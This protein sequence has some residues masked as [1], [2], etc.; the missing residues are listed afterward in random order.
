MGLVSLVRLASKRTSQSTLK[1]YISIKNMWQRWREHLESKIIDFH[2][3]EP[4]MRNQFLAITW[5]ST[6]RFGNREFKRVYSWFEGTVGPLNALLNYAG[7]R[8]RDL[9]MT[10]YP[11][12]EPESFHIRKYSDG[13]KKIFSKEE[14]DRLEPDHAVKTYWRG[15]YRR[16]GKKPLLLLTHPTLPELDFVDMI[17]AHM[18]ELC[19]QCF[20]HNVP[21][22]DAH[23]YIN[24]LIHRLRP[25]LDWVY[26]DGEQ[27]RPYFNRY[28]D[29]ELREIVQEIR[30]LYGKRTGREK[31]VTKGLDAP[32]TSVLS[33]EEFRD[34]V[35]RLRDSTD[36]KKERAVFSEILNHIDE[37]NIEH[38]DIEKVI[39]Q[40]L[41]LSSREGNEW[42]RILLSDLHHPRSL[43][44]VVFAGDT[45]LDEPSSIL[46]VGEL[47][48]SRGKGQVDLVIFLRRVVYDRAIWTPVMILEIKT[49]T[50][51][52]Y[53][54]YG[55][56]TKNKNVKE[57]APSLYAWKRTKTEDEWKEIFTSDPHPRTLDQ[58][59]AYEVEVLS[60]YKQVAPLDTTPPESLWKGVVVLDT[61]QSP[62]EV[63][64]GFQDLLDDLVT[65]I[66]SDLLEISQT[67]AYSLDPSSIVK[68]PRVAA[69]L[70]PGDGPAELIPEACV[71]DSLPVDNP[72]SERVSDD[73]LL[74]LYVPVSSPTSSGNAAAWISRN[75][76]LL[77]HIQECTTTSPD[78][79]THWVDL[80]GDYPNELLTKKRIGLDALLREGGITTKRYTS[81]DRLIDKIRFI[82]L[83]PTIDQILSGKDLELDSLIDNLSLSNHER[84][85][86]ER[87]VI[88]DG[89]SEFKDTVP[90]SRQH[91]I[92]SLEKRLLN[93]LPTS[94]TNIIWIDSGV[95][96]TRMNKHYQ[97]KC[98]SP[99]PYDSPRKMHVDEIIYNLPTSS[100]GFGRFLPKRDDERFIVQDVPA[101]APPWRTK[102]HVPHL[103][104]YSKK[105]RGGQRRKPMLNE[106]EV[107]G[108]NLRSM[109]RRGVTLSSIYS[110]TSRY[111][112][113]QVSELEEYA[114]TLVPST[115]RIREEVIEDQE[116]E[117]DSDIPPK[118][119]LT[120][121]ITTGK[122]STLASRLEYSPAALPPRPNK[123]EREYVSSMG[124]TRRWFYERVPPQD[125]S[126]DDEL[127][128]VMRPPVVITTT[129]SDLDSRR[130][131]RMELRR[132][133]YTARFLNGKKCLSKNL[134]SCCVKISKIC[135]K[136]LSM[137]LDNQKQL[138]TLEQVR[139]IILEDSERLRLWETIRPIRRGLFEL[140]NSVNRVALEEILERNPDVLQLYG[141]NLFLVF[142]AVLDSE[143]RHSYIVPLWQSVVE[144]ELYQ[145][146]FKPLQGSVHSKYDL[147]SIY[148]NLMNR[149]SILS[150]L[151]LPEFTL[152][153]Q[154]VGQIIWM[155]KDGTYSAW[156]IFQ[157]EK[158]M[159]AGLIDN[160]QSQWV[161]P[162]WYQCVS[163]KDILRDRTK[164]A[165]NSSDRNPIVVTEVNSHKILW[166]QTEG[167][168][169]P[170]WFS[171]VLEY[172]PPQ[173]RN[174]SV[175]WFRFIE[176]YDVPALDDEVLVPPLLPVDIER[177]VN[178]F[179]KETPTLEPTVTQVTCEVSIN[180][181]E[182]AYEL[183]FKDKS[184]EIVLDTLLFKDTAEL[185]NT[186]RHPLHRGTP[187][188]IKNG[189]LV[190]WD[191]REDIQYS[192][193]E[194]KR[195][196]SREIFSVSFLRP[197]IHRSR[198]Y[199][200]V[201]DYP[202]TCDELLSTTM[203][204]QATLSIRLRNNKF[205]VEMKGIS[206]KSSLS[207]LEG[208]ELNIHDLGFLTECEQLVDTK[209]KTRH[210]V[211]IDAKGLLGHRL[212]RLS[213]YP[214]LQ[215]AISS[216]DVSGYDWSRE[217]W[218]IE[219]TESQGEPDTITWVIRSQESGTVWMNNT[220]TFKLDY[221]HSLGQH[222]TLFKELVRQIVP[223]EYLSEFPA[224]VVE[225][226]RILRTRGLGEGRPRCRLDLDVRE[227]MKVA[228]VSKLE[229]NA[230]P[231]EIDTFRV[232]SDDLEYLNE[233]MT[234][235]GGPLTYYDIVNLEEFYDNI[236]M[237]PSK[238]RVGEETE[239]LKSEE[240]SELLGVIAE[241][242][243]V[244]DHR[245]LGHALTSLARLR[246]SQDRISDTRDAA[247]EALIL[248]RGCNYIHREVRSDIATVLVV[249]AE[250]I[251]R[252]DKDS[253]K[254]EVLLYEARDIV[255]S[256]LDTLRPGRTDIIVQKTAEWIERL[257]LQVDES[258]NH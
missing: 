258:K 54:L 14:A 98:I 112:K 88:I 63:F 251:L 2:P 177:Q 97:R 107:Y 201:Y 242:R 246:L 28:S 173:E 46:I 198:F 95:Q 103:I 155:E 254:V 33:I 236:Q 85:M 1:H 3:V 9:A 70:T 50:S 169:G 19:R 7:A 163:D 219:V 217:S 167:E 64:E 181:K 30:S 117:G 215:E 249:K 189:P 128:I 67:T 51:F 82:N 26:T 248:L 222:L 138:Y 65:R 62:L 49:K 61:D 119:L 187:L 234:M 11:F 179:L 23:R 43:K 48:V 108:E 223:L 56:R 153:K 29:H 53:N 220:F 170:V 226:E 126:K 77:N 154:Q 252:D 34:K 32:D 185:I 166:M 256:L 22:T 150:T 125:V 213:D 188:R 6:R 253:K 122:P 93:S 127:H 141:N 100:R 229:T 81:L 232:E 221:T 76:H 160:L 225:F 90:S 244:Q 186:L 102:I 190:M 161:R 206:G 156:I 238:R 10:R 17:R 110:D 89:W 21:R 41:A 143:L 200:N 180:V 205:C 184:R 101:S 4:N 257:L 133:L 18:V 135:A 52:D 8:L 250:V 86:S 192:G 255:Q 158:G 5:Q 83:R 68:T 202:K 104:D 196:D 144:W 73:R 237:T 243:E 168:D 208:V 212:S 182:R 105:F 129:S 84:S 72:F 59:D 66:T 124:I 78:T 159:V 134:R 35:K 25:F 193:C 109:Y 199:P 37:G 87:I 147:H 118:Q 79:E 132:L 230:R 58:L 94:D 55:L 38:R 42:H 145:L 142:L 137:E 113:R 69:I 164:Q 136:V 224:T 228:V 39:D 174:Q 75:W 115:L 162:S 172:G 99:L 120:P 235:D 91:I 240:D 45:M 165:L 175:P 203:G 209:K 247:E 197:L 131:R 171:S 36:D 92:R 194:V 195:G 13:S 152:T 123:A 211:K 233:L 80:M 96:H 207:A 231:K 20:I 40:V 178:A 245:G 176:T 204:E 27:G 74:T 149:A 44:Q 148:S 157:T 146:G 121:T 183:A 47:P 218:C 106:E 57:Y 239:I 24:L 116:Q 210:N 241:Y 71:P 12:P 31:S 111:S 216:L 16:R 139:D 191:H 227:G 214:R 60:E 15:G 140:L 130:T 151:S 114:L